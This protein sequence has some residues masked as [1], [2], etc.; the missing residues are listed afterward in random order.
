MDPRTGQR[1]RRPSAKTTKTITEKRGYSKKTIDI[2]DSKSSLQI[3]IGAPSTKKTSTRS[4]SRKKAASKKETSA[5]KTKRGSSNRATK[6]AS[7]SRSVKA[8]KTSTSGSRSNSKIAGKKSRSTSTKPKKSNFVVSL[9]QVPEYLQSK[10]TDPIF[11][12]QSNTELDDSGHTVKKSQIYESINLEIPHPRRTSQRSQRSQK[13][14]KSQEKSKFPTSYPIESE[15]VSSRK[16]IFPNRVPSSRSGDR[17]IPPTY[18]KQRLSSQERERSSDHHRQGIRQPR[19]TQSS[20]RQPPTYL[21]P[22]LQQEVL[23]RSARASR[24]ASQRAQ[25]EQERKKDFYQDPSF[26]RSSQ[27]LY[28]DA[29][30]N[31][32]PL[33]NRLNSDNRAHATYDQWASRVQASAERDRPN[34][35]LSETSDP[36]L[37]QP[38]IQSN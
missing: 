7:K 10:P 33:K 30:S 29:N 22:H 16:T 20:N 18:M 1:I 13:S 9:D 12:D 34:Q 37:Y 8:K 11:L 25:E 36:V 21:H 15:K 26:G 4:A 6:G 35:E 38:A 31:N 14:Q 27:S 32:R 3:K 24:S 2:E 19:N 23:T 5:Q 17:S 28:H